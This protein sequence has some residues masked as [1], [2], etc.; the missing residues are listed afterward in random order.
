MKLHEVV[1]CFKH[2][3]LVW[4]SISCITKRPTEKLFWSDIL[5]K[6]RSERKQFKA[7][8]VRKREICE[9]SSALT[10]SFIVCLWIHS[11]FLSTNF[12]GRLRAFD[13][14]REF[15]GFFLKRATILER[16][17]RQKMSLMSTRSEIWNYFHFSF[18][19]G[20][21]AW[22]WKNSWKIHKYSILFNVQ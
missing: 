15:F 5:T 17:L 19:R 7:E 10:N 18:D 22:C 6:N 8:T 12:W 2:F 21:F 11:D 1:S 9:I 16:N 20:I 3:Q 13:D 4:Y 14:S